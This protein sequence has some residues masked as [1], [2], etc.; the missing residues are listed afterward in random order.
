[1]RSAPTRAATSSSAGHPT[2]KWSSTLNSPGDSRPKTPSSTCSML[3]HAFGLSNVKRKAG[4]WTTQTGTSPAWTIQA[5][6]NWSR[7]SSGYRTSSTTPRRDWNL[8]IC[9]TMHTTSHVLCNGST[10]NVGSYR[11]IR[12]NSSCRKARLLLVD[13]ARLVLARTLGIMGMTAPDRM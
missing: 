4:A 1:M 9:R 12:P 8:T 11:T 13:A 2:P 5:R 10:K 6:C 7:S 3:T